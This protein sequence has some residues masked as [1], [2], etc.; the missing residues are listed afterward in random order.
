MFSYIGRSITYSALV[1]ILL[2]STV[3]GQN[4]ELNGYVRS[5]LGVL[6]NETMDYSIVQN[7]LDLKLKRSMDRV[8]LFANPYIY[9]YP[10]LKPEIGIREAYMDIFFDNIDLRLGKQQIIWGKADGVFITDIVSPKDLGEF[11][12]RDFDE[13]RT[14]ITALKADYYVGNNTFEVVWIPVFTPTI[15]PDSS[16]IWSRYP[17]F[18]LPV[19]I[20]ESRLS[21]SDRLENSEV[22]AKFSGM[23]SLLDYELMVGRMWDDDPALHVIPIM[24]AG[25]PQPIGL[26]LMPEHHLLTLAGGSFSTEIKGF[27]LR[28]EAAYYIG[29]R[30]VSSNAQGLPIDLLEKDY[31]HYL[32]GTDFSISSANLSIQFIQQMIQDY[33]DAILQ[34]EMENTL[35]LMANRTFLQ[36]TLTLQAFAYVGLNKSDALIRPTITY[37][38]ADGFEIVTGLNLFVRKDSSDPGIFGYYDKNDMAYLK[39]K[40]SF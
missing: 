11:L 15:M 1:T 10:N 35:T 19:V 3:F 7:T 14:G 2:I 4:L 18:S 23:S 17:S 8:S 20:D 13:I 34:D 29:K 31:L 5:Y 38:F 33:Q 39:V 40:Y 27:I 26:T 21:V 24:D 25:D 6:T 12:L 30:F 28:S 16:S 32:V 22:F 37:D 9:Q 36:E